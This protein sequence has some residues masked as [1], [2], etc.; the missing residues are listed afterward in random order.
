M[1]NLE[2]IGYRCKCL[3]KSLNITQDKVASDT[4]YT[5]KSI[6]AFENGRVNNAL[7]LLWY[8]NHDL[9]GVL[10]NGKKQNCDR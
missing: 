2:T 1:N 5:N 6:S 4:G 10:K 9:E 7:I 3:R 8:I